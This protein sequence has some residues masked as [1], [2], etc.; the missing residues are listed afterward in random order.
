MITRRKY[1]NAEKTLV[2]KLVLFVI[3]LTSV[4][5]FSHIKIIIDSFETALIEEKIN[6]M[7]SELEV[8]GQLFK[9]KFN[10]LINDLY[11]FANVP[12]IQG[13]IRSKKAGGVDP[14]DDSTIE[15]WKARLNHLFSELLKNN[16]DYF[17][18]RFI[19]IADGGRE[20]VRV[21]RSGP[22]KSIR[23]VPENELQKKGH[24]P[25]VFEVVQSGVEKVFF[26]QIEYN[27][28]NLGEI[29]ILQLL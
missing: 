8:E 2:F 6:K 14:L 26:S 5:S 18:M 27:R 3:I 22:E 13:I 10:E 16:P 21:D 20:L 29:S 15:H 4:T 24:R 12:P 25:Y 11:F 9:N 17:Q 19:G 1:T 7:S 23:I 28:E